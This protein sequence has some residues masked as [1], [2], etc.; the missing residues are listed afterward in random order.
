MT[1]RSHTEQALVCRSTGLVV[2]SLAVKQDFGDATVGCRRCPAAL[3]SGDR[4]TVALSC[5][6][7]HSWEIQGVYCGSHGV[8]SV[9]ATMDVRAERQAVVGAVLEGSGYR[10][11]RGNFQPDALTLGD[12]ELLDF[13]PTAAGY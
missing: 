2:E 11:P 3:R 5:Y 7:D 1:D 12:V 8:D 6:E 4:V 9:A 10:P 13:S